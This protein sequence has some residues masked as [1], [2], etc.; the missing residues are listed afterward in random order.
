MALS[1]EDHIAIQQLYVRYNHHLDYDR[2]GE[3]A[4]C[5]TENGSFVAPGAI[6]KIQG[7]A[8]L[9]AW[10]SEVIPQFMARHWNNNL[11]LDGDGNRAHGSCYFFSWQVPP[12]SPMR[13]LNNGMY[14]DELAKVNGEWLF[15]AR[16]LNLEMPPPSA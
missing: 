9:S 8:A 16:V 6:D 4:A 10:A 13:I 1:V 5:Y 12:D 2:P 11:V 15:E 14:V 7:R 3:W